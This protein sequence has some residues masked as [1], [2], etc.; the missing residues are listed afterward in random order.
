[1]LLSFE[2]TIEELHMNSQQMVLS[3]VGP[4]KP[5]LVKEISSVI[6]EAGANLEDSR[7][8][9]L[10]GDF[11]LIV[12]F[13]GPPASIDKVQQKCKSIEKKLD[14][15][16]NFKPPATRSIEQDY[17]LYNFQV[18]GIDQPG[19]VH[20]VSTILADLEVNVV[21][22]ESRLTNAAFHGTSLFTLQAELEVHEQNVLDKL[23]S[24]LDKSCDDLDLSYDLHPLKK[25]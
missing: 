8:A 22:L 17:A 20:L 18:T 14:F 5:G 23:R 13:S 12:L 2:K 24:N 19:I 7:M 25:D 9:V 15:Q 6:H 21:S 10:A 11:A 4:D 3:A 16:I 1:M